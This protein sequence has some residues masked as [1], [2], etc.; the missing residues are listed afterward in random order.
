MVKGDMFHSRTGF[1]DRPD[2]EFTDAN[3]Q[4]Q[5]SRV[6]S[7]ASR[8]EVGGYYRREYRRVPRQL[9]HHI[10]VFDLDLQHTWTGHPRH[11]MVWGGALRVNRDKTHAS[12]VLR[13]DPSERTYPVSSV[14]AQD[15]IALVAD[16]VFVTAGM[17]VERNAF[18]GAD[19]Q[20]NVRA[21]WMLPSRQV[22]WGAAARAVRRPTRFD[23]DLE[24]LGP[25]GVVLAR[26]SDEFESEQLTSFEV[27]YRS[28]LRGLVS[29][30]ATVFAHDYNDLRSQESPAAAPLPIVVGN[31][32][33]GRSAGVELGLNVQPMTSWRTHMSYTYV[34]TSITRDPDSRDVGGGLS[35]ANDPH[36]LFSLRTS[37]DV[38]RQVEV[39]GFLRYVG[40][41][42]NPAVPAFAE[43]NARIAW[44]ATPRLLLALVGQ[45]L[46]HRQHPEFGADT[47]FR[48]E[49]E[50]SVRALVTLRLP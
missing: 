50:R 39:D 18:S 3:M 13:F 24:A 15:E 29:L 12:A 42:P 48:L 41:L 30:D 47:P 36:H 1:A 2:G 23:D 46:A 35:E 25:G 17:K 20:P 49:F 44:Q 40:A 26:G 21:R 38:G 16:R 45:D 10:D 34:E 4:A 32:L 28:G 9:T 27:G 14:F 5:V 7:P 37:V 43:L 11:Q 22:L 8:L 33:N 19:W 31:S 6:F